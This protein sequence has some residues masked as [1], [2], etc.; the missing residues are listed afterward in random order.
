M[1]HIKPYYTICIPSVVGREYTCQRLINELSKQIESGNYV[2]YFEILLDVDNKEVSIGAK[3]DRLHRKA[4]G[5]FVIS[6]DDDD[7]VAPYFIKELMD[8][9]DENVDTIGYVES[10]SMN[11]STPKLSKISL[12]SVKW[13]E[14]KIAIG[15]FNYFRTPYFK[16]PIKTD[17]VNKV[18]VKD[19]RFGEDADFS[20]RIYPFLKKEKFINKVMYM[21]LYIKTEHNERYGIKK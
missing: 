11:N 15:G 16:N 17:I 1:D 9:Y 21:Y 6:I 4:T 18:G 19:M 10:V 3:R 8:N 7:M 5:T 13:H 2:D 12:T 20:E 14:R